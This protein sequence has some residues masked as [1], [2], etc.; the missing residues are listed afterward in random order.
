[1]IHT[2]YRKNSR[3][4]S[5]Y[6]ITSGLCNLDK[7]LLSIRVKRTISKTRAQIEHSRELV[8]RTTDQRTNKLISLDSLD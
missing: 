2:V 6:D 8:H 5:G 1:M 7:S 4:E 3:H